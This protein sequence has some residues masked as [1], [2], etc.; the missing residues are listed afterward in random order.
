MSCRGRISF[1]SSAPSTDSSASSR[2]SRFSGGTVSIEGLVTADESPIR[3]GLEPAS[4][5]F[6]LG[7]RLSEDCR[8]WLAAGSS[9]EV[10]VLVE[11][12]EVV[13]LLLAVAV[14]VVLF[15]GRERALLSEIEIE[16][17]PEGA[18][19]ATDAD[20][21]SPEMARGRELAMLEAEVEVVAV[22]A[23][24]ACSDGRETPGVLLRGE[25]LSEENHE[26]V[27]PS[28]ESGRRRRPVAEG[29]DCGA[30]LRIAPPVEEDEV[31]VDEPT[32]ERGDLLLPRGRRTGSA[33]GSGSSCAE[34]SATIVP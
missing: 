18:V 2:L 20:G 16:V 32:E 25:C 34:M 29:V 30:V 5:K 3:C 22:A 12:L 6:G 28:A 4:D 19:A 21:D 1:S 7:V 13:L 14:A 17:A 23:E 24:A 26:V 15:E 11:A 9:G 10:L 8:R 27:S 31:E 33:A